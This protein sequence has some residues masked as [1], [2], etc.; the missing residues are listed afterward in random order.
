M[1]A[2]DLRSP[3][4]LYEAHYR[5]IWLPGIDSYRV[6]AK[7]TTRLPVE[8]GRAKAVPFIGLCAIKRANLKRAERIGLTDAQ[9]AAT[10]KS[11]L[12][13]GAKS[14]LIAVV[15]LLLALLPATAG[16]VT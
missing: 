9:T 14:K 2:N 10:K 3:T 8:L 11:I 12:W 13:A 1:I 5:I 6:R 15:R 16:S 7:R 4:D